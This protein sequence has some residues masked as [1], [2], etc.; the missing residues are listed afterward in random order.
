MSVPES[1]APRARA[2]SPLRSQDGWGLERQ[3]SGR[4]MRRAAW[5][6]LCAV[7]LV[8]SAAAAQDKPPVILALHADMSSGSA[9]A[10]EAIRR[11]ALIAISEINAQ[12]GLLG[13]RKLELRVKDHHG[14]PAR[15]AEQLP[16]LAD[17]PNLVAVLG[18]LHGAAVIPTLPFAHERQLVLLF[19][20]AA[21][22]ELID[23]GLKPS[24][25]FR[26][27][28]RDQLVGEFLIEQGVKRGHLRLGLLLERSSWGRSSEKA[29]GEA[30]LKRKL[31]PAGVQWFNWADEDMEPQL[32]ALERA[33]AQAIMLVA[34]APEGSN[35]IK[36]MARRPAG[37]RLPLYAHWGIAGGDFFKKVG[38]SL[39]QVDLKVFQTF[40]FIGATDARTLAFVESYHR[41]F[42][43][44]RAE[45]IQAPTGTAHA[46]DAVW[47]LALAI[48]KAGTTDRPKVRDALEQLGRH[49]GLLRTY[50]PAF[51]ALDHEALDQSDYKLATFN[52]EG[53]LV[54]VKP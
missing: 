26:V 40:S 39:S 3:A 43:T 45:D 44:K 25:T 23:H 17:T 46:Y 6:T 21:T 51:T 50:R 30:L 24:Y 32:A 53:V 16:E 47:L 29:M 20:W 13:G 18:G 19:P 37:K 1:C 14:V 8:G 34:N 22:T 49:K 41:M 4:G 11:G 33:G 7:L 38:P 36:S 2:L 28:A 9:L 31:L 27:S 5:W 42:G 12:G 35:V 15:A 48:Q 52:S 10:G 54:P